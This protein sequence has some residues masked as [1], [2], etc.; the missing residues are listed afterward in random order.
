M[1]RN[2]AVKDYAFIGTVMAAALLGIMLILSSIKA[3]SKETVAAETNR[4]ILTIVN[5]HRICTDTN[6]LSDV[7]TPSAFES[8]LVTFRENGFEPVSFSEVSDYCRGVGELP[9]KPVIIVFEDGSYSVREYALPLLE[10]HGFCAAVS[11]IGKAAVT[12]GEDAS[13]S[14]G[15]SFLDEDDLNFLLESGKI[16]LISKS[17]DMAYESDERTGIMQNSTEDFKDYRRTLL[18]DTFELQKL[19]KDKLNY[20]SQVYAYPFGLTCG[21]AEAVIKMCGYDT[22]LILGEKPNIIRYGRPEDLRELYRFDR[23]SEETTS[24]FMDRIISTAPI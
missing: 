13:P 20:I 16:E 14:S 2:N 3:D 4:R 11:V 1:S 22:T 19:F 17:Y 18:I 10:K 7:V 21:A 24:Q 6:G 12:A 15:S 9:D 8:D 23:R 5:Y